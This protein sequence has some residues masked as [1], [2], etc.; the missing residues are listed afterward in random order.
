MTN[1]V[2]ISFLLAIIVIAIDA[3]SIARLKSKVLRRSI[4]DSAQN[5]DRHID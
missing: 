2:L 5:E 1:A 3:F 4:E